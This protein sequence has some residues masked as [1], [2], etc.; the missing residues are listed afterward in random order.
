MLVSELIQKKKASGLS[1]RQIAE[2]S[3][4]PFGTVQRIFGGITKSPRSET[5][6]ALEKVLAPEIMPASEKVKALENEPALKKMPATASYDMPAAQDSMLREAGLAY[7]VK[8]AKQQGT[9]TLADYYAWPEEERIELIDG[10]IY[11][12]AAP[13]SVHQLLAGAL[14]ATLLQHVLQH[15]GA[16][17]PIVSPI[18]VQL[19]RDDRTMVQPDVVI[20]CD[21]SQITPKGIYGAPDF[22]AEV[23]S[24]STRRKDLIIKL[25]KYMAAGVREY[26]LI[27]PDSKT[28]TVYDFGHEIFP[29]HYTFEDTIPVA[30][31]EGACK[32]DFRVIAEFI[33]SRLE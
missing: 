7:Q 31:W 15:G 32:V 8:P 23:L 16:C 29:V 26:W 28:V 3:G 13:A 33:R 11:D 14:H 2:L 24:P 18:D 1:N 25:N 21:K 5:L 20:V 12:M 17:T 4:V 10:V 30:V 19:D 9:Y 27:D 22:V 6:R